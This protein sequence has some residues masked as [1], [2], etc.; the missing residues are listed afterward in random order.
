MI[1]QIG[2]VPGWHLCSNQSAHARTF[3]FHIF[4]EKKQTLL[5]YCTKDEFF[6]V[7]E[8]MYVIIIL[9]GSTFS[10]TEMLMPASIYM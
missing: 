8:G 3:P 6:F 10:K 9:N 2:A 7:Q 1:L 4:F 5:T